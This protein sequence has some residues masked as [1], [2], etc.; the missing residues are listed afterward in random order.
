MVWNVFQSTR[1]RATSLDAILFV[2]RGLRDNRSRAGLELNNSARS[3]EEILGHVMTRKQRRFGAFARCRSGPRAGSSPADV[4][5]VFS[6]VGELR[7]VAESAHDL[8]VLTTREAIQCRLE[9][10]PRGFIFVAVE[11]DRG[12]ANMLNDCENRLALLAAVSPR[13]RPRRRI[14]SAPSSRFLRC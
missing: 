1:D 7:N 2:L 4:M 12:P 6:D 10:V 9:L 13:I 14:S 11:A 3:H 8:D 5:S